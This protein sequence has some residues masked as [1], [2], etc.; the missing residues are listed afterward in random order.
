[1]LFWLDLNLYTD[2]KVQWKHA[3]FTWIIDEFFFLSVFPTDEAV[4][5]Y[6]DDDDQRH[7][8]QNAD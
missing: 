1:M 6:V 3:D 7:E 2:L 5:G 8:W 4:D